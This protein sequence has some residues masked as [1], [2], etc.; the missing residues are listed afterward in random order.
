MQHRGT[1]TG[2]FVISIPRRQHLVLI[3]KLA[4]PLALAV[5]SP[6]LA[7][8]PDA[9]MDSIGV[10]STHS[11]SRSPASGGLAAQ[12]FEATVPMTGSN[13][14]WIG[15]K[16]ELITTDPK[17]VGVPYDPAP[18]HGIAVDSRSRVYIIYY[19]SPS[20]IL[21]FRYKD[22]GQP[23]SMEVA[24]PASPMLYPHA[25]IVINE[26]SD[27]PEFFY[28]DGQ[29]GWVGHLIHTQFDFPAQE[30]IMD[31]IAPTAMSYYTGWSSF[32]IGAD[33]LGGLHVVWSEPL[34]NDSVGAI[35]SRILYAENTSGAWR[36]H[37]VSGS[38]SATRL[39][40]ERSG[41]ATIWYGSITGRH[42]YNIFATNRWRGD[43]TWTA[44][45]VDTAPTA[46]EVVD[47]RLGSDGTL[48]VLYGGN[49]CLNCMFVH[50]LFYTRRASGARVFEPWHQLFDHAGGSRLF[51]DCAGNAHVYFHWWD[52]ETIRSDMYYATNFSGTWITRP[53]HLGDVYDG[54]MVGDISLY[55][56]RFDQGRA[57]LNQWILPEMST[58]L[59][60]YAS[61]FVYFDV[62]DV[63]RVID[64]VYGSGAICDPYT[65]DEDCSGAVDAADVV[66]IINY[67]FR[68][69]P[70]GCR[71]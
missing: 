71:F 29:P 46:Y 33:L 9:G 27:T 61:E 7:Q 62:F 68:N 13:G 47:M 12:T 22:V 51:V 26:S 25:G 63:V 1:V 14:I 8:S 56:D 54:D 36:T 2:Y 30:W 66:W 34:W 59:W 19:R 17:W 16:L 37:V 5:I 31:T 23:W 42:F 49:E 4:A 10:S 41:R 11:S 44:D 32:D 6:L 67:A 58:R 40:L 3:A 24:L 38:G 21:Y 69:G 60:Y 20:L 70:S 18:R 15:A 43:T 28:L 39:V 45:T 48:H 57:L 53:F 55:M 64:H 65:Y 50:R 35:L 52:E